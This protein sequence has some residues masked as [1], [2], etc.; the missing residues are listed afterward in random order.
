MLYLLKNYKNNLETQRDMLS[1]GS[2]KHWSIA[3][4]TLT[5]ETNMNAQP[6]LGYFQPLADWLQNE[7]AKYPNDSPGFD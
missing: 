3:L 2:N 5:G 6:L 7:N 1:L 4:Q